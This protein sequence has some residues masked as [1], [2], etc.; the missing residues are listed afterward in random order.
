MFVYLLAVLAFARK[1]THPFR[2]ES[3][4]LC[5]ICLRGV[6]LLQTNKLALDVAKESILGLCHRD[7]DMDCTAPCEMFHDELLSGEI[8]QFSQG[9]ATKI[10][11]RHN[12]CEASKQDIFSQLPSHNVETV[13][14]V[15][16]VQSQWSAGIYKG[17]SKLSRFEF[18]RL[19]G[20]IVD[21][22]LRCTVHNRPYKNAN[23]TAPSDFDSATNWP[24]CA[25]TIGDI[26]DQSMCGCC[27]AFAAAEAASDRM[28]ISSNAQYLFPLSAKQM[29]FCDWMGGNG[30]DGGQ[31][32]A[33]WSYI[34]RTGL[35][36]GG[37]INGTGPFG[38]GYCSSFDQPHCHHHGPQGNDPYPAEGTTGCPNQQSDSCPRTCDEDAKAPHN[39]FG[40]DKYHYSGSVGSYEG[41]SE[42]M[43]AIY[44]G[45]PVETAFTVY[46][47]F[48]NYVS[49][50]YTHVSGSVEGGHA[51]KIVGWGEENGIKYWKVANSW[52]PYWGEKGYFRIAR[53]NNECGIESQ[54]TGSEGTWSKN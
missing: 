3:N 32:D 16:R 39:T 9:D 15:N 21:P 18:R 33:P 28:C 5:D 35:V 29:C 49:G 51:V 30:C 42:I 14:Y 37:Q 41:E 54:T 8:T 6:K 7:E 36:T 44:K 22:E 45:G 40:D 1:E 2:A 38:S 27:W 11:E 52:N 43:Q 48:S 19:L 24:N 25:K 31:I 17:M 26:R 46:E 47:D 10:C 13:K 20:A 50:I 23:F 4:H 34:K 12:W 53:G